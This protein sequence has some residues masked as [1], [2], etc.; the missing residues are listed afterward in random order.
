MIKKRFFVIVAVFAFIPASFA[1]LHLELTQGI[2][3]ALPIAIVKF[4]AHGADAQAMANNLHQ[5]MRQ[6]FI[7]TG[8]FRP[9]DTTDLNQPISSSAIDLS[10][11]KNQGVNDVVVGDIT[12]VGRGR[13][14][15]SFALVDVFKTKKSTKQKIDPVLARQT[16]KDISANQIRYLGHH[17]DDIIY[18]QLTGERGIFSTKIAYVLV[19]KNVLGKKRY[20]LEISDYDGNNPRAILN[21]PQPI[22]S[23][24]WAPDARHIAYV[25]FESRFAAIYMTD[26]VTGKRHLI[27]EF[28][29]VNG[30]PAFSP[31]GRNMALVLTKTDQ[32]KIYT[33][34]IKSQKLERITSGYSIDTEPRWSPDGKRIIFTSDRAGGPQI[35]SINLH[36]K[37]VTRLTFDG[38]Y[39]ARA[40]FTADGKNI[41][42]LHRDSGSPYSI[43]IMNLDSGILRVLVQGY[44]VQSPSVAPNGSMIIYSNRVDGKGVL[45]EV[46]ADGKVQLRLPTHDGDVREPAWSP[47]WFK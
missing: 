28:P 14:N 45:A 44:D 10:Y 47:Y 9:I 37:H 30:A 22:M 29:G 19:K 33:M 26:V 39:N 34:N 36:S 16:F 27:S 7:N 42:L 1:A 8:R 12:Q 11:W 2:D 32:L 6:D 38:N 15:V 18:L 4:G 5:V 20:Y 41:V 24:V 40:S 17:I 21:S 43:A 3:S 23:P 46:S 13:Y 31:S 35:Y 25:S